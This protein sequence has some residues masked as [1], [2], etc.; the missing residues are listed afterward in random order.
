MGDRL[1][2]G[3]AGDYRIAV[4]IT[5]DTVA[6]AVRRHQPTAIG[7]TALA[8]GMTSLA[9]AAVTDKEWRR[10]SAQWMGRGPLG[11]VHADLRRPGDLRAYLTGDGVAEGVPA[12]F[13]RGGLLSVI[14]Q[15]A[16][17][18][19][20]QGQVA[21]AAR[22]IDG[23]LE[24]YLK[25]SE[26]IPSVLRVLVDLDDGAPT[27][28]AGVLLQ[29][30]PGGSRAGINALT[31]RALRE[32]TLAADLAIDELIAQG[33]PGLADVDWMLEVPLRWQCGCSRERVERGVKMLG[34]AEL[35]EMVTKGEGTE[36]RCD[37]CATVYEVTP[38]DIARLLGELAEAPPS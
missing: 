5:T 14:R 16:N 2:R 20:V 26:Q 35:A 32:R 23:D 34:F 15:Q 17:D 4:A 8:R 11:T 29:T 13:G 21:L 19:F 12:G 22:T 27:A 7:A 38:E 25:H 6:E 31:S 30:L 33:V 3:I 1:I 28:V 24:G 37:F 9:L 36:A 10:W 18:A